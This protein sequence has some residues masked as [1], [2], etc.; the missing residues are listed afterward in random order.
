VCASVNCAQK[1][2][3]GLCSFFVRMRK[4]REVRLYAL[5]RLSVL[6]QDGEWYRNAIYA[7]L[8]LPVLGPSIFFDVFP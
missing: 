7:T 4:Q 8:S 5:P 6:L 2:I 3:A 1:R